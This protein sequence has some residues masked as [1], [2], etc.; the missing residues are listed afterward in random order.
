[1]AVRVSVVLLRELNQVKARDPEGYDKLVDS[2][3]AV[4]VILTGIENES[5]VATSF[6]HR[7]VP[8]PVRHH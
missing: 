7:T 2:K 8:I 1:M 4:T 3:G 5:P 6:L